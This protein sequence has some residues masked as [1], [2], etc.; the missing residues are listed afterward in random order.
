MLYML[1]II[2]V[3]IVCTT[4]LVNYF[5]NTFFIADIYVFFL[6]RVYQCQKL[7]VLVTVTKDVHAHNPEEYLCPVYVHSILPASTE[8]FPCATLY[9]T[10]PGCVESAVMHIPME[11]TEDVE[12][13]RMFAIAVHSGHRVTL[14]E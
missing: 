4:S 1:C 10:A 12:D 11:T 2:K 13:C 8:L 3:Y 9:D 5:D 7:A 14:P 6:S